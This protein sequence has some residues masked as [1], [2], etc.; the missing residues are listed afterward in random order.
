MMPTVM[1]FGP[2]MIVTMRIRC[3]TLDL[4][5]QIVIGVSVRS[6]LLDWIILVVLIKMDL[7]SVG[8]WILMVR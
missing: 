6:C 2:T 7:F 4:K 3:F 8:V 5:I 1:G